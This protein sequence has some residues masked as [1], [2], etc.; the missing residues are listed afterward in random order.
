MILTVAMLLSDQASEHLDS[1]KKENEELKALLVRLCQCD[2]DGR[3]A[4]E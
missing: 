1:A 3:S 4:F 2:D